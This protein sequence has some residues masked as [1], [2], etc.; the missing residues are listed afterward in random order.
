MHGAAHPPPPLQGMVGR[1]LSRMELGAGQGG[2]GSQM[3]RPV[4]VRWHINH[5][6]GHLD[7]NGLALL[8]RSK[9]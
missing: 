3:G 5:R 9:D 4:Q 8:Q 6:E 1:A 2:G 7:A